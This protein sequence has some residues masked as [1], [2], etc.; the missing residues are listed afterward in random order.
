MNAGD[1]VLTVR[2]RIIGTGAG[3]TGIAYIDK[4]VL[5]PAVG[6]VNA[7]RYTEAGVAGV[8]MKT[9]WYNRLAT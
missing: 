7:I 5:K 3:C 9:E 8:T 6:K 1:A 4:I 2:A